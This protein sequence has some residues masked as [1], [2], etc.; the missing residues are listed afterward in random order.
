MHYN[1]GGLSGPAVL[2]VAVRMV[3]QVANAVK[4]PILGM[5]GI[6]KSADAIEMMLAGATLI[7]VGTALFSDPYAPLK[8]TEGIND[9]LLRKNIPT[10]GEL[11]GK[12]ILN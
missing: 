5:G 9:Y 11:T 10:A 4:I 7:S 12:V 2:P 3:W 6:S 1:T 8:I